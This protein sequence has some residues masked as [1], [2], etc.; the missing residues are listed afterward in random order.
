MMVAKMR[1]ERSMHGFNKYLLRK[2]GP[3]GR[4]LL[5]SC[6]DGSTTMHPVSLVKLVKPQLRRKP[7]G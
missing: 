4:A 2:I 3:T 5:K 7:T 1:P 6:L